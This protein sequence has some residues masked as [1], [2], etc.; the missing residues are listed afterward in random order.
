MRISR[1]VPIALV[2]LALS[3]AA[4]SANGGPPHRIQPARPA[5]V[6]VIPRALLPTSSYHW[7]QPVFRDVRGLMLPTGVTGG[8]RELNVR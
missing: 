6:H 7:V 5:P 2:G 1:V 8:A 4:A 3:G